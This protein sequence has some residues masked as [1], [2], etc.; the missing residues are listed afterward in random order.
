MDDHDNYFFK[1]SQKEGTTQYT[2]GRG[3][4]I[5]RKFLTTQVKKMMMEKNLNISICFAD[6]EQ[7]H[8]PL[9]F[10]FSDIEQAACELFAV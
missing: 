3:K 8:S 5:L 7:V 9:I 1:R 4:K 2:G 10:C 6:L